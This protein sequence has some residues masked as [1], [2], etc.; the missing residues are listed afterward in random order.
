MLPV[1]VAA[2]AL[3]IGT[4][5]FIAWL[6]T[7]SE[8]KQREVD[9]RFRQ[10]AKKTFQKAVQELTRPEYLQIAAKVKGKE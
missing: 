8:Q 9:T 6:H 4:G 10:L 7:Q 3:A 5:A 2:Y 1:F